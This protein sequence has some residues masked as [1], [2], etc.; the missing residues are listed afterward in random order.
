[1]DAIPRL[2]FCAPSRSAPQRKNRSQGGCRSE[3]GRD[4]QRRQVVAPFATSV[5]AFFAV[6]VA[7]FFAL[8]LFCASIFNAVS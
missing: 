5:A 3:I 6:P 2:P 1:M 8:D 7:A 4:R